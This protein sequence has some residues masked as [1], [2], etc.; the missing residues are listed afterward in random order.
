M[1]KTIALTRG[2]V[3]VVDDEDHDRL[4]RLKWHARTSR[5]NVYAYHTKQVGGQIVNVAMH[6]LILGVIDPDVQVD[7]ESGDTLDNRRQNLRACTS[8]QNQYNSKKREVLMGV[9]TSSRYKGVSLKK[10]NH[11][12]SATI[13]FP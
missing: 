13:R 12:W 2:Y 5:G 3:T 4:V 11:R 10:Q 6:R 7:H 8:A 1:S 9:P